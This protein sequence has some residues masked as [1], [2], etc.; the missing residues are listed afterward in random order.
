MP[1]RPAYPS[2]SIHGVSV[3]ETL[4]IGVHSRTIH[5]H[6]TDIKEPSLDNLRKAGMF[7]ICLGDIRASRVLAPES[8]A[9]LE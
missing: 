5:A 7:M 4:W 6:M 3:L 8:E 9:L 1:P 2:P